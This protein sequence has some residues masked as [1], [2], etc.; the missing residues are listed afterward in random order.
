M[1]ISYDDIPAA[2]YD[3]SI[4]EQFSGFALDDS[5]AGYYNFVCPNPE[6]GDINRP[7]KKKAYIYTDTWQ[8]VCY[9]CTPMMPYA[10]WLRTHDENAYQRLLFSAFGAQR[11]RRDKETTLQAEQRPLESALPFKEGELVPIMSGHPLAIAGLNLCR[12]R[13][14]RDGSSTA[15][16]AV[17]S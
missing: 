5:H 11:G 6:C 13:R 16:Q 1:A 2:V 4:H 7:N 12:S 14:I 10:K 8:Y 3:D 9:K 17:S 15:A